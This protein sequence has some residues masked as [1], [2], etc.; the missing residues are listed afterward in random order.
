M[1]KSYSIQV[2]YRHKVYFGLNCIRQHFCIFNLID[3][4]LL[5][6]VVRISRKM[7]NWSGFPTSISF[8]SDNLRIGIFFLFKNVQIKF[9]G[10]FWWGHGITLKRYNLNTLVVFIQGGTHIYF[11]KR[12]KEI[13]IT[14]QT[15]SISSRTPVL[16]TVGLY[17]ISHILEHE[18]FCLGSSG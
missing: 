7:R 2:R 12:K 18:F 16:Y 17:S 13:V 5:S 10:F 15:S 3:W 4:R 6:C 11:R 9:T 8:V 1:L 14:F